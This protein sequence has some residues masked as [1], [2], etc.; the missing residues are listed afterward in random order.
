[1][2]ADYKRKRWVEK[3]KDVNKQAIKNKGTMKEVGKRIQEIE[4]PQ[5]K[6]EIVLSLAG[7]K[8]ECFA[9]KQ[10]YLNWK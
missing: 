2:L 4:T 6:M 1:M 3:E 9:K 5:T 10:C 7:M 8:Q